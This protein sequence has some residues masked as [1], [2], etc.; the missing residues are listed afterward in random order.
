[1]K[2]GNIRAL[3]KSIRSREIR[4]LGFNMKAYLADK[5][6]VEDVG[7]H[8]GTIGCIAGHAVVKFGPE[9]A[10]GTYTKFSTVDLYDGSLYIQATEVESA[11]RAYLGLTE[12]QGD[13]LFTPTGVKYSD[14]T[15]DE[16]AHVLEMLANTGRVY[17]QK[18]KNRQRREELESVES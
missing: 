10:R 8:C 2:K 3:A 12:R 11:A 17:W 16:A 4:G 14:V 15:E 1:M 6:E 9:G 7:G 18:V 5:T 13:R